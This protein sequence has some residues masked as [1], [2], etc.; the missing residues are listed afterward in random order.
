MNRIALLGLTGALGAL[1]A[2]CPIFDESQEPLCDPAFEA[3]GTGAYGNVPQCGGP[4]DCA[5]NE[6]CGSD[7]QCHPGDCTF[8]GCVSGYSCVIDDDGAAVCGAGGGGNGGSGGGGGAGGDGN[9]YCGNPDDC[10]EGETCASDGT[11]LPGECDEL[12]CVFGYVC[13]DTSAPPVCSPE[14]P[15]A[16][17][18]DADCADIGAGYKCVSGTCTAPEDQC[19]DQTQCQSGQVCADGKC[20]DGCTADD[21]C[22]AGWQCD[23]DKGICSIP[24]QPCQITSD[25]ASSGLVCVDGACVP[26]SPDGTCDDGF[27]WVE[28]GCIPNQ[29]P[30]FVCAQDGTQDACASGSI[31][32]HHSCYI[33]CETPNESACDALPTFDQ[34]KT[35]TT[36]SGAHDVCGSADNLGGECDPTSGL[37][38]PVGSICIDGFCK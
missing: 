24:T 6:T 34:C 38:C 3:C 11:C 28:N 29:S 36:T 14:N 20:T 22:S 30:T 26:K 10:G 27:V 25:C 9:V 5:L 23:V 4:T 35:V 18:Q 37:E 13:D 31:C 8:W 19:F 32:L 21:D 12:G 15:A 33:S 16:C 2:G 7:G 1:T 17:G